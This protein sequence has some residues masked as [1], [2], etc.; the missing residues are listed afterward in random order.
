MSPFFSAIWDQN[1]HLIGAQFSSDLMYNPNGTSRQLGTV[2][3]SATTQE[4]IITG[5]TN[6]GLNP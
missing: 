3:F 4:E 5:A 1:E 2:N 6:P